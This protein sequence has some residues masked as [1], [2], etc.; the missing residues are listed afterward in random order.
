M[1]HILTRQH[2]CGIYLD[3]II[4]AVEEMPTSEEMDMERDVEEDVE[5][6]EARRQRHCRN[7]GLATTWKRQRLHQCKLEARMVN[8]NQAVRVA[9]TSQKF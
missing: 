6:L 3:F 8:W 2:Y 1:K 4:L 5:E 7:C 9:R